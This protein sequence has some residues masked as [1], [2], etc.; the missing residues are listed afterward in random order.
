M[1]WVDF[2]GTG[3]SQEEVRKRIEKDAKITT[4]YG[5]D[6]GKG[7]ETFMRF[8]IATQKSRVVE[9]VERMQAAFKD[10]Q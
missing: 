6:M 8:N 9:A 2:V 7:G 4:V 3:M 1:A 5:T 10:L